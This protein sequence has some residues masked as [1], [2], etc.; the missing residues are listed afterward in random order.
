MA[1]T[2]GMKQKQAISIHL[3]VNLDQLME[4]QQEDASDTKL[5]GLTTLR[6]ALLKTPTDCRC[7]EM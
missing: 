6:S 3:T 2:T 7:Y 4:V 5:G 1:F